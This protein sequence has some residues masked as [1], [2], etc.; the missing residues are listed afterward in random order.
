MSDKQQPIAQF[1]AGHTVRVNSAGLTVLAPDGTHRAT[2]PGAGAH[3]ATVDTAGRLCI[4]PKAS[5]CTA[6]ERVAHMRD[7]LLRINK[8]HAEF[9]AAREGIPE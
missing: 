5:T 7:A 6:D 3:R 4:F 8:K 9:W 2:F 1:T